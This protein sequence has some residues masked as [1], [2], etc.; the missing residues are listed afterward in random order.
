MKAVIMNGFGP[1]KKLTLGDRPTPVPLEK[2]VLI[3]IKATGFNPVDWKIRDGWYGG[4]PH[5]I[6]GCDCSGIID[7]VGPNVTRFSKGDEVYGMAHMRGSNGTYAEFV[8]LPEELVYKKPTSLSFEEAAAVPLAALT[9]YRATR[10]IKKGSTVFIAGIGGGVGS[11]AA[12]FVKIFGAK[13]IFTLAKEAKSAK[14]I[15]ENLKVEKEH[16]VLYEGLSIEQI[17]ENLLTLT[18]GR[19]F[20]ATVDLVGGDVKQL[21]LELTNYSGNFSTILPEDNF[22]FPTWSQT[23]IPF[24]KNLS[25][26]WVRVGAELL[27]DDRTTWQI[28]PE[29][30]S[31]ITEM[32]NKGIL[33]PPSIEM[34][35]SLSA[36]A[37]QKAHALLETGRVKG[38]LVMVVS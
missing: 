28:Y 9:A 32:L 5:Q 33:R 10:A 37:V 30:F 14:F 26:H 29:H 6:L 38:K 7:S 1:A 12:Q 13:T 25:L 16:I 20:E 18:K 3:R 34:V 8:C 21:C 19:F 31:Q 23:S 2:E 11:F 27:D 24:A 36:E 35:G 15:Q 17:K 22:S 4:D